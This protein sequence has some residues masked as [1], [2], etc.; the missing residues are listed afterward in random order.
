MKTLIA[1]LLLSATSMLAQMQAIPTENP[2]ITFFKRN[3]DGA[4]DQIAAVGAFNNQTQQV[5][6]GKPMAKASAFKIL[7]SPNGRY[8]A[9]LSGE[10]REDM[11]YPTL[12]NSQNTLYILDGKTGDILA[13]KTPLLED[14]STTWAENAWQDLNLKFEGDKLV[15]YGE[16]FTNPGHPQKEPFRADIPLPQ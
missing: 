16:L 4:S 8:L 5:L 13:T 14:P 11:A 3:S 2:E 10:A 15:V 7:P 12:A 9:V 1:I 6:W